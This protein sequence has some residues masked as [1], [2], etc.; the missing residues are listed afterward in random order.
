MKCPY[1]GIRELGTGDINGKCSVCEKKFINSGYP[2]L[3]DVRS[4]L[5]DL[6]FKVRAYFNIIDGGN[7]QD[8]QKARAHLLRLT[9]GI[10][11]DH[12]FDK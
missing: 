10:I 1:C 5:E 2:L 6:T 3:A 7:S 12:D 4:D 11:T 8:E 9:Q